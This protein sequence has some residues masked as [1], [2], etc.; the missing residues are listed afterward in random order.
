MSMRSNVVRDILDDPDLIAYLRTPIDKRNSNLFEKLK[1]KISD[2]KPPT[3]IQPPQRPTP[4]SAKNII[5][6][7]SVASE[8]AKAVNLK[9]ELN[10]ARY[11]ITF[12]FKPTLYIWMPKSCSWK[13]NADYY[14]V[15]R[16]MAME[17]LDK[18]FVSLK[19]K[20]ISD[21][22]FTSNEI[23]KLSEIHLL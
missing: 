2:H 1:L 23:Y 12:P 18:A 6:K 5:V 19:K 22:G 4:S 17:N 15:V 14:E 20:L 8:T 16:F 11:P 9:V 13:V 7:C 10:A 21:Y 3:P